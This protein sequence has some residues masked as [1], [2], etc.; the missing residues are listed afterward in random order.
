[1]NKRDFGRDWIIVFLNFVFYKVLEILICDLFSCCLKF[2][3]GSEYPV[4]APPHD[5]LQKHYLFKNADATKSKTPIYPSGYSSSTWRKPLKENIPQSGT[6][7]V[8]SKAVHVD[9]NKNFT[10]TLSTSLFNRASSVTASP[11]K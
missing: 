9:L 8:N 7:R 10:K 3:I 1:M 11:K 6:F 5:L 2:H 4:P